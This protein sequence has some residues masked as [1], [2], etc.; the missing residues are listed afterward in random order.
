[1]DSAQLV[2][3]GHTW[4]HWTSGSQTFGELPSPNPKSKHLLKNNVIYLMK[5]MIIVKQKDYEILIQ[6]A[7]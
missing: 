2:A 6:I 4:R 5:H 7:T 1:M 3:T